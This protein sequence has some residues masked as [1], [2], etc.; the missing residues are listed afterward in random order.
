MKNSLIDDEKLA[1]HIT[2]IP[3]EITPKRDLW[4]GI[5][6]AI[7]NSTQPENVQGNKNKKKSFHFNTP[8]AWA[9]SVIIAVL[10]SWQLN[11][12]FST[13]NTANVVQQNSTTPMLGFNAVNFI[14]TN[15]QQQKQSLLT[16]YGKPDLTQ[17]PLKM[18]QELQQL[19]KAQQSIVKALAKE[20][21]NQNLLNLLQWT[22]QQELRLIEQL[23][24]PRWQSI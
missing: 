7:S 10:V 5:E 16:S 1:S 4:A 6:H 18:Q 13:Q 22:Q 17:L 24:R 15:F 14:Q 8:L 20:K 9:A 23:Y 3:K 19:A 21:N 2:K 12:S 11:Q